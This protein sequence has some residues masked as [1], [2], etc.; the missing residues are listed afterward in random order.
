MSRRPVDNAEVSLAERNRRFYDALWGQAELIQPSRFNTWPLVQE[1][2][3]GAPERLEIGPGLRPRLPIAGTRFVDLSAQAV[4]KL[5]HAGG[6]ATMGRV[7]ALEYPDQ[8]FDLVSALDIIEHVEDDATAFAEVARVTRPGGC[9]LISVP[10]HEGHWTA[11]DDLVGHGRRY[12]PAALARRLEENGFDVERSAVYG[13]QPRSSRLK[14]FGI[15]CLVRRPARAIWY[16]SRIFMPLGLWFQARLRVQSG[17]IDLV[18][19]DEVLL[20]CRKRRA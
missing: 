19:V 14:D 16:Y 8:F 3:V 12:E 18:G 17:L 2:A 7:T 4:E 15:R 9:L 20:V 6:L 1:L 13:M 10:L 5:G 11:F